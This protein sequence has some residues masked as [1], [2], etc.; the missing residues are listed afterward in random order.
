MLAIPLSEPSPPAGRRGAGDL[1]VDAIIA[2]TECRRAMIL[3]IRASRSRSIAIAGATAPDHRREDAAVCGSRAELY[4]G[5]RDGR[6]Q[7]RCAAT[8][9]AFRSLR[10]RRPSGRSSAGPSLRACAG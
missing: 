2:R 1:D 9:S 7:A 3:A 4:A 10:F 8:V 6:E 5:A